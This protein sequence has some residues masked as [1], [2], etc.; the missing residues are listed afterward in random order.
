MQ[1]RTILLLAALLVPVGASAQ[2]V[3][4]AQHRCKTLQTALLS[5]ETL[6]SDASFDIV[7]GTDDNLGNGLGWANAALRVQWDDGN[8]STTQIDMTCVDLVSAVEYPLQDCG[9]TPNECNSAPYTWKQP[10]TVDT[11]ENWLWRINVWG[12]MTLRCT[13]TAS[14]GTP[15]D[16]DSLSITGRVCGQ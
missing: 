1:L 16:S 12:V 3:V 10:V 7:I 6:E 14:A 13:V 4:P 11:D 9:S 2:D 5:A 8:G 15:G